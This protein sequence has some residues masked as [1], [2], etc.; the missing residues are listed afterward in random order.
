VPRLRYEKAYAKQLQ[1]KVESIP[2]VQ[3]VKINLAS[4]SVVVNY[5]P[6]LPHDELEYKIL[7]ALV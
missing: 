5:S 3:N 2:E 4:A 6:S 7:A 1:A